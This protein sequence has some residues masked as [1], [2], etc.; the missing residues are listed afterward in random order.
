MATAT[1]R[2]LAWSWHVGN[3]RNPHR[4]GAYLTPEKGP[5]LP[6]TIYLAA[7]TDL[8]ITTAAIVDRNG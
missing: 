4:Q 3:G 6:E 5:P 2:V 1:G 8:A 7:R